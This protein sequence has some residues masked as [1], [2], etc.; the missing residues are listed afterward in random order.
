MIRDSHDPFTVMAPAVPI[1]SDATSLVFHL[2]RM[3]PVFNSPPPIDRFPVLIK[4][5][6]GIGAVP[7]RNVLASPNR[8]PLMTDLPFETAIKQFGENPAIKLGES[9][10]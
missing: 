9:P 7:S 2:I 6:G 1:N 5:N 4:S 8:R 3:A 10:S